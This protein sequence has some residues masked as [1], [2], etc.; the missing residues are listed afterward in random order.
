M[1]RRFPSLPPRLPRSSR[2]HSF[3]QLAQSLEGS[4]V[5]EGLLSVTP[6]EAI[7]TNPPPIASK[8]GAISL[9]E[10][11]SCRPVT[12]KS[13]RS[14]FLQKTGGWGV[15]LVFLTKILRPYWPE[16]ANPPGRLFHRFPFNLQL[17]TVN[18]LCTALPQATDHGT[19]QS[20]AAR[21]SSLATSSKGA[22]F[23]TT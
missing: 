8:Q 23:S 1:S 19:H 3:T 10:A 17:W 7:L 6:L 22:I 21:H 4:E 13:F 20:L 2:G 14:T 9:L 11:H 5:C 16:L 12:R 18:L 15:V